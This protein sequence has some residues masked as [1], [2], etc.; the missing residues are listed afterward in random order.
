MR[1]LFAVLATLILT[2]AALAAPV[3]HDHF[4]L[5]P[6]TKT[7]KASAGPRVSDLQW[8]LA[9]HKPN[10]YTKIKPTFHRKPN[11]W[12][13]AAT[14]SAVLA[15]KYRLGYPKKGECAAKVT[16][17]VARVTPQFF[18]ILEGKQ[19]L[20]VCWV[21]LASKRVKASVPGASK[22]A[23]DIKSLELSQLGTH[24]VPYGSN[25]GPRISYQ[26]QGYGPYQGAT[27]AFG[28]A[29]CA[30]FQQWAFM[31]RAPG[32]RF[33]NNSAFTPY[34]A[35]WARKHGFLNAKAKVGEMAIYLT[36]GGIL[37]DAY[38]TGFISKVTASGYVAIEGNSANSVRE[39]YRPFGVTPVVF[40]AVPG[41]A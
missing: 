25:R 11:G 15:Y 20:S 5:H 4:P 7:Q 40:V 36:H 22:A 30:S 14:T 13:G 8:L 3:R 31:H 24:E 9:G 16:H 27:G 12:F 26:S 35:E 18:A 19:R 39:V 32:G 23:L 2:S 38:H 10:V 1:V 34:I 29:W 17:L 6:G 37:V 28:L 21:G 41:V 33:A